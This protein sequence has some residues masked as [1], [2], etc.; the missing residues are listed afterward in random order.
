MIRQ[1]CQRCESLGLKGI[2]ACDKPSNTISNYFSKYK[3]GSKLENE[4][5][6]V[7]IVTAILPPKILLSQGEKRMVITDDEIIK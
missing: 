1:R 7:W 6:G 5:I 2:C 3:I 4:E